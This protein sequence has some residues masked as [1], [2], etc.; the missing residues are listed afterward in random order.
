MS[1]LFAIVLSN[2]V[3]ATMLATVIVV[4][5]RFI[6]S[7]PI[8]HGLWLLVL[9][10]LITPPLFS[11][12]TCAIESTRTAFSRLTG[13]RTTASDT[14][15][16]S[17]ALQPNTDPAMHAA[18]GAETVMSRTAFFAKS[19]VVHHWLEIAMS[20]WAVGSVV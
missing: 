2:A 13:E 14:M 20:V 19:F 18:R 16:F 17:F 10:K 5:A 11:L 9:L 15:R 6:K 8:L 3:V 7:P 1:Q 4:A 12:P